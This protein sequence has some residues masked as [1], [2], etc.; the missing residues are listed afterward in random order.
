VAANVNVEGE[1]KEIAKRMTVFGGKSRKF[2]S[3]KTTKF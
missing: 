3:Q 2:A 1:N